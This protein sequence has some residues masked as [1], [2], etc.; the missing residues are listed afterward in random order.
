M[1]PSA[2]TQAPRCLPCNRSFSSKEALRQHLRS[3]PAHDFRCEICG[4]RCSSEEA[5][6]QHKQNAPSHAPLLKCDICSKSFRSDEA[7]KQHVRDAP[8]HAPQLIPCDICDRS[9]GSEEALQQHMRDAPAHNASAECTICDKFFG[10]DEALQQHIRDSPAHAPSWQCDIC[11]KSFKSEE[12]LQQHTQSAKGHQKRAKRNW[13]QA[14]FP[15]LHPKVVAALSGSIGPIWFNDE[16]SRDSIDLKQTFVMARFKCDGCSIKEW[17][18]GK[19]AIVIRG[20]RGNGYNAE[21]FNQHCKSCGALGI[22]TLD[23]ES[24]VD[25][26]VYRLK[27]WAGVPVLPPFY[28]RKSTPPHKQGL[29]EGCIQGWCEAGIPSSSPAR[30][31]F[32]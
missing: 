15:E 24:Y 31:N 6:K 27:V 7:L 29:C 10:S 9:F 18:S 17:R 21:V 22:M 3:S 26:V 16:K 28:E 11:D 30:S 14:F 19:V 1:S 12:A 13:T 25:R 5:L 23:E 20:Y 32:S 4:K 2:D 8:A